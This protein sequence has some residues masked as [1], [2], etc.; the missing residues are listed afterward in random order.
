MQVKF[1]NGLEVLGTIW[2]NT[3]IVPFELK[4][5]ERN[6][7]ALRVICLISGQKHHVITPK[8]L[9]LQPA[10]AEEDVETIWEF[11][12]DFLDS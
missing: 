5:A 2:L 4:R 12:Q 8:T 3:R 11:Q 1:Q 10:I 7:A 9:R 6:I